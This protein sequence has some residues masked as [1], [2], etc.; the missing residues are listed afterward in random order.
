MGA[1]WALRGGD[2]PTSMEPSLR[3]DTGRGRTS[4]GEVPCSATG[5]EMLSADPASDELRGT[6][7]RS[8][9]EPDATLL[10]KI[11]RSS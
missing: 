8:W 11:R 3:G 4:S 2:V 1:L 5:E 9:F 6:D 7:V 10:R